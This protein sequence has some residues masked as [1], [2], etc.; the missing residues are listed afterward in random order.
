MKERQKRSAAAPAARTLAGS[1]EAKRL[2]AGVLEVLSGLRGPQDASEALGIS[3]PRYYHLETRAL[4]G[5]IAALEPRPKGRRRKPEDE[6]AGLVREK[7]QITRELQRAQALVRAA[8]RAVGITSV[9]IGSKVG[10]KGKGTRRRTRRAT[11]RAERTIEA[12]RA[13]PAEAATTE[14]EAAQEA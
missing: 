1:T 12:L 9:G 7:E 4:G 14:T 8:Q 6:I 2:A 10:A 13:G 11:V 3:L 5:M